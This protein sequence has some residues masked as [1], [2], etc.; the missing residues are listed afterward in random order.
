MAKTFT[1]QRVT[2][3]DRNGV[4]HYFILVVHDG[5][6]AFNGKPGDSLLYVST[7]GLDLPFVKDAPQGAPDRVSTFALGITGKTFKG[8]GKFNLKLSYRGS[9]GSE[10]TDSVDIVRVG[11]TANP[12]E[13]ELLATYVG[14]ADLKV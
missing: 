6:L 11:G 13:L 1:T 8:K 9:D 3:D 14:V 12:D 7:E 5:T 4:V 10:E 2:V